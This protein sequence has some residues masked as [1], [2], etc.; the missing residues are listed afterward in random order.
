MLE[1][2][3]T[4]FWQ[5][6]L[7]SGL[8]DVQGL[9]A[10]WDAI[11]LEKRGAPEHIDRRLARQAVQQRQITLWQAQQL[12]AGRTSG[13]R[14]DRYLLV[15]LIGHGGMGRVYLARDTRLDREVAL[16]ILAPE[17]MNNPRA[18][19]RFRREARVGAQLQHENLVRIYDFGESNGRFFLVMEYIEGKT[20]GGL[21]TTQGRMPPATA[22]RLA[23][24]IALG[25]EHAHRKGL[26][27]RDVNP[28]N[29]LV[30][31]EGIAK[32]ADLGLAIDLAE[33][34]RVT[35]EGATVGTFDY[36]AP[37]QAR[38]SHAADIRSDIY[39]L[40][41]TI[42]HMIAGHVPFP[43]PSLPEKLFAHQALEPRPLGHLV[44]DVPAGLAEIVRRMMRKLPEERY[45]TPL[46]VAQ[47]LEPFVGDHAAIREGEPGPGPL[48]LDDAAPPSPSPYP[49]PRAGG[50][51]DPGLVPDPVASL[52]P[53]SGS[54]ASS[55]AAGGLR[56]ERPGIVGP[57]ILTPV[58]G[59]EMSDAEDIPLILDLGP[60]PALS[61]SLTRPR[62]WFGGDR[63]GRLS[64]TSDSPTVATEG[65]RIPL[66]VRILARVCERPWAWG[67]AAV[68]AAT[69]LV[70]LA[71]AL[72][73]W[74]AGPP[75]PAVVRPRAVIPA[76]KAVA[77]PDRSITVV[78]TDGAE[79]PVA[80]LSE[81]AS[82]AIGSKGS[83]VLRNPDPLRLSTAVSAIS[84]LTHNGWLTI[85]AGEGVNPVLT[86]DMKG[87]S[88][89]LTA[90][91]RMSLTLEGLTI[92]AR[93]PDP[94]PGTGP[95]PIIRSTGT[96]R[97]R[98]CT[99]RVEHGPNPAG[100]R[101]I[102]SDGGDL[103]VEDC[104]FEGFETALEVHSIG[105]PTTTVRQT[106]IVPGAGQAPPAHPGW[107]LRMAF[108]SGQAGA[109]RK[110][111]L[112]HCTV[113][114][115]GFLQIA[116]FGPQSRLNVESKSCAVQAEALAAWEPA[117]PETPFD[118]QSVRWSGQ[119]NQLDITGRSWVV[120]SAGK[121]PA[122]TQ[123]I[124]DLESWSKVAEEQ[125]AIRGGLHFKVDPAGRSGPSRAEDFTILSAVPVTAG[126]DPARVGPPRAERPKPSSP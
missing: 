57:S 71:Y 125:G 101:A 28:Y 5:S 81:A 38:H 76:R 91:A 8:I 98:R 14:V 61:E 120:R 17:R 72:T 110:L 10:C 3:A 16:K 114:G 84:L 29:V 7:Q 99:L 9:T 87:P 41:C 109:T 86:I 78:T 93:Y 80:D 39:S 35:R 113:V 111:I 33:E 30:T 112:D 18:I 102:L 68:L 52:T 42:Y 21:I 63:P 60:E 73:L 65:P 77:K 117:R 40:G 58:N 23:R 92:V 59:D 107:G 45:A 64:G 97:L 37:E 20:I 54:P 27:H 66:R 70:L 26:I 34:E 118:R 82:R 123:G 116:G 2:Q 83:V 90:G 105:G 104:F 47:A 85:R 24:Q 95:A 31:H 13:F 56:A 19:A 6:A 75:A 89:F 46:Q 62:S 79:E 50:V 67:L 49:H 119:G 108:M 12:L 48:I 74:F 15:D 100:A 55:H 88:P 43:S 51:G 94:S 36:V 1:P 69:A 25:L 106:M 4:R 44:P 103:T 124:T 32:L 121:T 122:L 11:P 22:A 96:T 126:A 53:S 115:S